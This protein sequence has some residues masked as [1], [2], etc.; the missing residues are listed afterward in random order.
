MLGLRA[1][2]GAPGVIL[3][4]TSTMLNVALQMPSTLVS[5]T[6]SVDLEMGPAFARDHL[7][8]RLAS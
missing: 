1:G 3:P 6:A 5:G 4:G 8:I 7:G 2:G